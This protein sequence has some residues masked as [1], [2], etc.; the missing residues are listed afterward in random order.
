MVA[1]ADMA[2]TNKTA[3]EDEEE[4]ERTDGRTWGPAIWRRNHQHISEHH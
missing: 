4:D 1:A 2:E 3:T